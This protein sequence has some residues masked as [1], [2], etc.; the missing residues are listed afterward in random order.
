MNKIIVR[1]YYL[2][3]LVVLFSVVCGVCISDSIWDIKHFP[4]SHDYLMQAQ[5]DIFTQEFWFPTPQPWITP[6][7]FAVPLF[8]KLVGAHIPAIIV[9][10]KMVHFL[11]ALLFCLAV[12]RYLN[13][14]LL[15]YLLALC[16]CTIFCWWNI[17]GWTQQGLS[18]S[19]SFSLLFIWISTLL[20]YFSSGL[21]PMLLGI[22]IIVT[23]L[24]GFTRDNWPMML[25]FFY[26]MC[27]ILFLF[28]E[29][30]NVKPFGLLLLG[31]TRKTPPYPP[32]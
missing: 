12:S 22:H 13:V 26:L 32:V 18:E 10:Q 21:K 17:L 15:K 20:F 24:F 8:Y 23:F 14:A 1:N 31:D 5:F 25:L 2:I 16:I 27:L 9:M 29:R 19:L 3:F 7:P 28:Y 6:R 11:S 4:D 30:R